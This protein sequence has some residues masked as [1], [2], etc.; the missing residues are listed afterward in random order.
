[1]LLTES[2]KKNP[3][4]DFAKMSQAKKSLSATCSNYTKNFQKVKHVCFSFLDRNCIR[5]T[6]KQSNMLC[7]KDT[8]H[9]FQ[10]TPIPT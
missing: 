9:C 1:M 3:K 5:F 4:Y 2:V 8:T 6:K 7:M 10:E